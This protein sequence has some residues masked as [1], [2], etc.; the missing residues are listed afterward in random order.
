M[1]HPVRSRTLRTAGT[2][3]IPIIIGST[4]V[5][6]YPTMR[7]S[8]GVP[9]SLALRAVVTTSAAAPSLM[10]DAFP[11]VTVPSFLLN[12]ALSAASFSTVVP[13]LGR[14]AVLLLARYL[15]ALC[16][17]FRGQPHVAVA[18]RAHQALVE[19]RVDRFGVAH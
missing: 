12:A 2:G 7:A 17:L 16:D 10:P 8:G 18:N 19:H 9:I 6:T 15:V 3:P 5:D 4:P 14:E 11:A 1:L 13:A